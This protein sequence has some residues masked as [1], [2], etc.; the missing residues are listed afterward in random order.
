VG[1]QQRLFLIK[2]SLD[3]ATEFRQILVLAVEHVIVTF[4]G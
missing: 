2:Q 3:S 1:I 4:T